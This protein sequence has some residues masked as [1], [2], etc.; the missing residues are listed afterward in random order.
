M[1]S[2]RVVIR[3]AEDEQMA[4]DVPLAGTALEVKLPPDPVIGKKLI[5][6]S[7]AERDDGLIEVVEMEVMLSG[8]ISVRVCQSM[9]EVEVTNPE[10]FG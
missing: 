2:D 4:I 7:R 8:P 6:T 10:L 9:R 1:S 3:S 5:L